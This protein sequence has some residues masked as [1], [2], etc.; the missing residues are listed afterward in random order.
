M[1]RAAAGMAAAKE[2]VA[3]SRPA[4]ARPG[5]HR[6]RNPSLER[7]N[8]RARYTH[9][10]HR[11]AQGQR[12]LFTGGS[13]Q[14]QHRRASR[15]GAATAPAA[16]DVSS[17]PS[18]SSPPLAVKSACRPSPAPPEWTGHSSTATT[19]CAQIHARAAAPSASPASAAASRQSLLAG[20]A[21]L[22]EHN[23]RLRRQN[24]RLTARLSEVLGTEVFHESGIEHPGETGRL[25]TR[26]TELEQLTRDLR[27]QLEERTDELDAACSQPH[28]PRQPETGWARVVHYTCCTARR[29]HTSA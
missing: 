28:R 26:V 13:P 27:Q 10:G 11:Q 17:T 23:Q 19:T 9:P 18:A 2:H 12:T 15:P 1:I 20:L 21:N 25:R 29:L 3:G 5:S 14:A 6:G 8:P 4:G 22:Q 24:H 16:G 7:H